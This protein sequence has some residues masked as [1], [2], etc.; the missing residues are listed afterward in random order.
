LNNYSADQLKE[1]E[2][3]A[4]KLMA[5]EEIAIILC[6]DESEFLQQLQNKDTDA[7]KAFLRGLLRTKA[8]LN[9]SILKLAKQGSSPAQTLALKMVKDAEVKHISNF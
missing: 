1:I 3:F 4:G 9:E 7:A 5:G 6:I 8:E 2:A